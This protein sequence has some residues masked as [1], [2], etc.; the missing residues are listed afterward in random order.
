MFFANRIKNILP[1]DRVLEIGPG[2]SPHERSDVL[3]EKEFE[4][5]SDYEAQF[6]HTEKL[7]T[8]KPVVFYQ[9]DVFP[10]KDK[11]FDY[12]I[13]SHVLEHVEDIPKFLSEVFRVANKGYFEYPTILYEYL[14][15]FD[16]HLNYLKYD[17]KMLTYMKKEKSALKEFAP[18]QA[19]FY[20][21]LKKGHVTI[22]NDLLLQMMEGFEW[23]GSFACKET[24]AIADVV[25]KDIKIE[26]AVD[27]VRIVD[28]DYSMLQLIKKMVKKIIRK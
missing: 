19:F 23:S 28:R 25:Q 14:Y 27:K 9:G 12:V 22:I 21:S 20:E 2:A 24:T 18:V 8:T 7:I 11:E 17:G 26:P 4:T 5:Q 16:V 10:F 1:T 13:C 3:L 15:N 6:G